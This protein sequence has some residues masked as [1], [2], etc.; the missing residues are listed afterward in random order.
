MVATPVQQIKVD[1]ICAETREAVFAGTNRSRSASVPG[2]HFA[3][4]KDLLTATADRF[5]DDPLRATVGV[6]FRCI[7]QGHAEVEAGPQALHL[8]LRLG[9]FLA[10]V[11]G[12]LAKCRDFDAVREADKRDGGVLH[13]GRSVFDQGWTARQSFNQSCHHDNDY[14]E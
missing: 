13:D 1:P 8:A 12:S 4:E 7:N 6:H 9:R 11:P 5:A 3:D 10:H 2:I 14:M